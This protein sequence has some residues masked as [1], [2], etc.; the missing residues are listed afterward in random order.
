MI[1]ERARVA[2]AAAPR[3]L[4]AAATPPRTLRAA[5]TPPR[6]LHVAPAASPRPRQPLKMLR[7]TPRGLSARRPRR[8]RDPSDHPRGT[9]G[10]AATRFRPLV[11]AIAGPSRV[12]RPQVQK[13]TNVQRDL[14]REAQQQKRDKKAEREARKVA[15]A[16]AEA[17]RE[18]AEKARAFN[19]KRRMSKLPGLPPGMVLGPDGRPRR[20]SKNSGAAMLAAKAEA[21]ALAD[22]ESGL[23]RNSS[24]TV[25]EVG[26]GEDE[27]DSDG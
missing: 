2:A 27:D 11:R 10:A 22:L 14:E 18:L 25:E 7:E 24:L 23:D 8:R 9:R 1:G 15:E 21:A 5:V 16:K 3:T 26:D 4:R 13:W 6:T 12:R 17:D 20:I 19:A